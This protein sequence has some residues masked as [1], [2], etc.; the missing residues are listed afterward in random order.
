LFLL[1]YFFFFCVGRVKRKNLKKGEK[2]AKGDE[3]ADEE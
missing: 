1:T 3:D 2:G